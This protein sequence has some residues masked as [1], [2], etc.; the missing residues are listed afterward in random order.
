MFRPW[1][2]FFCLA[3]IACKDK[4]PQ[5]SEKGFS[6]E[7]FTS[8]FKKL[9]LPYQLSDTGL[10][11][12]MDTVSIRVTNFATLISDS[13]KTRLFG[14]GGKTRYMP[15]GYFTSPDHLNFYLVK[16]QSGNR[17]AVILLA[18]INDQ[19]G[20]LIPF[21]V[22]DMDPTTSQVSMIDRSFSIQRNVFQKKPGNLTGEGKEVYDF[23][24]QEKKFSLILTNPLNNRVVATNPIDT[25][26]RRHKFSG[27]YVKDRKNLISIRDGRNPNQLLMYIRLDKNNGGCTGEMKGD[28]L[29]TSSTTAIYRQ[30]GDPCVL[31]LRF[32]PSSL[33]IREDEGCGSHRGL[34]CLFE[35]SFT[36]KKESK[37]RKVAKKK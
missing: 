22:P 18:F 19:Y 37:I 23:D 27:D 25:F 7:N 36:R 12:N 30:G 5:D 33:V 34:D 6:F 3:M 35:G 21:L 32:T 16:A 1:L 14:K 31:S 13:I 28:L 10:L 29:L 15:I 24:S 2:V 9:S 4:K 26:S 8:H 20:G 17:K 11:R